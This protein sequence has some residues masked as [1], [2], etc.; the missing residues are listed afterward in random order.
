[1]TNQNETDSPHPPSAPAKTPD[2]AQAK[3]APDSSLAETESLEEATPEPE[4]GIETKPERTRLFRRRKSAQDDATAGGEAKPTGKERRRASRRQRREEIMEPAEEEADESVFEFGPEPV[5]TRPMP[6]YYSDFAKSIIAVV[7][8]LA[9]TAI[10]IVA[11]VHSTIHSTPGSPNDETR[12]KI[13]AA[14]FNRQYGL[15]VKST[16]RLDHSLWELGVSRKPNTRIYRC[17]VL[18]TARLNYARFSDALA[19][20]TCSLSPPGQ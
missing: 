13:A 16:R 3:N 14:V 9:A 2:V 4:S 10:A 7:A 5:R 19:E 12:V 8:I 15:I 1:V 20:M 17:F 6:K 11:I 18:D